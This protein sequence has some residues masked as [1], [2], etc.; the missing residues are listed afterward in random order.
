METH[1]PNKHRT[2][3]CALSPQTDQADCHGNIRQE[4]AVQFNY[5]YN[6]VDRFCLSLQN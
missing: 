5:N 1:L 3:T 2:Y 4:T 6:Y